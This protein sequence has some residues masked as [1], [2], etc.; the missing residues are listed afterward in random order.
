MTAVLPE[1]SVHD[2]PQSQHRGINLVAAARPYFGLLMLTSL[3]LSAVGIYAMLHMPSGIYPEVAFP[4]IS[5]IAQTPGLGVED[6]E[7]SISAQS[8]SRSASC[9]A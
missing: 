3:L 9:W 1:A 5:I 4:R 6:V 8:K 7:V 2:Q